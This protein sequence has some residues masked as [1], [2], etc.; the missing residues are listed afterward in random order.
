MALGNIDLNNFA[1]SFLPNVLNM[2]KFISESIGMKVQWMRSVPH[3]KSEDVIFQEYTLY[4][5]DCPK[6]LSV[7]TTNTQY[8]PGNFSVDLF[9]VNYEAPFEV[10]VDITS[11][12]EVFGED[13]MPQKGDIV[14]VELLNC[15]Y[16]VATSTILYGFAERETGFKIELTKYNPKANRRES[17]A[18]QNTIDNLT[19]SEQ[20]LFGE[21]ISNDVADIV[22]DEQTSEMVNTTESSHDTYKTIDNDSIEMSDIIIGTNI[23]AKSYYNLNNMKKSIIYK[24]NDEISKESQDYNRYFSCWFN[25]Q[26]SD[27]TKPIQ[28]VNDPNL[29]KNE[30]LVETTR[31]SNN[32]KITIS[33]GDNLHI[34]AIVNEQ[35]DVHGKSRYIITFNNSEYR[36][37]NKKFGQNWVTSNYLKMSYSQVKPLLL[38]RKDKVCNFDI[39]IIG[40]SEIYIKFG[41]HKKNIPLKNKL[42][43]NQWYGIGINLGPAS[44]LFIFNSS[45]QIIEHI[46]ISDLSDDFYIDD[47]YITNSN[48]FLT[49][50]RYYKTKYQVSESQIKKDLN[51]QFIKNDSQAIINDSAIIPNPSPYIAAQK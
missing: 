21:H 3:D 33:R 45:N 17:E 31:L 37:I 26:E 9:G 40:N 46:N 38:G 51:S 22:D 35:I 36:D 34:H 15:L 47:F 7:V 50:I 44:D 11:W 13:I 8:N 41:S 5:V 28:L 25:I 27:D 42:E 1:Q 48:M 4:D 39:S 12:Q 43:S 18:V 30:F 14:Y 20:E 6:E 2:N 32:N 24:S 16:E 29:K 19:N 49:N 23:I 10:Q